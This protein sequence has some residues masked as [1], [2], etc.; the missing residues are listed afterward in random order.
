[1]YALLVG[2]TCAW[3]V[4]MM[5]AIADARAVHWRYHD[6]PPPTVRVLHL[7]DDERTIAKALR[8]AERQSW[9]RIRGKA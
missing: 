3:I 6:A 8:A 9:R 7:P 5:R 2:A 4:W 1:M